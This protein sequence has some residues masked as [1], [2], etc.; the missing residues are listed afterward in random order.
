[1]TRFGIGTDIESVSRFADLVERND[2]LIQRVFTPDE[3][4]YSLASQHPGERFAARFA[5]KEA[6]IKAL[7]DLGITGIA[8][9]AVEVLKR[10]N[11]APFVR[12]TGLP[13]DHVT[14]RISLSHTRE[15]ATAFALAIDDADT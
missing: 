6:V 15:W 7:Y 8:I 10:P 2:P 4:R 5:G 13:F 3:I 1:M 11:G 14:I 9:P 12:V